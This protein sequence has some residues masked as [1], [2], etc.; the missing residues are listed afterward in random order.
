M[1][2]CPCG[3]E[4]EISSFSVG[5]RTIQ[6]QLPDLCDECYDEMV[7][8]SDAEREAREARDVKFFRDLEWLALCPPLFSSTKIDE[9]P[10]KDI[11]E[12]ALLWGGQGGLLFK[13]PTGTGKTRTAYLLLKNLLYQDK[14]V[15]AFDF[16]DFGRQASEAALANRVSSWIY[17]IQR[18][19]VLLLDDIG[20]KKMTPSVEESFFDV[21]NYRMIHNLATIFTFN[22]G[23]KE[24]QRT[25]SNDRGEAIVRRLREYCHM[26]LFAPGSTI[27]TPGVSVVG[28]RL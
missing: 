6:R 14:K 25:M 24:L 17:P 10:L 7:A 1:V 12:K 3:K 23:G 21:V 4:H 28:E 18:A 13:G 5:R 8:E 2:T 19:D 22:M 20:K 16:I 26:V 9:L 11:S 27:S 15:L